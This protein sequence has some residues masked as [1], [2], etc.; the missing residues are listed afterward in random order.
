[1]TYNVFGGTLNLTQP[2]QPAAF[3]ICYADFLCSNTHVAVWH[4]DRALFSINIVSCNC[5]LSGL[6]STGVGECSWV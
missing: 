4:S 1:M 6:V 2:S 3:C 5:S